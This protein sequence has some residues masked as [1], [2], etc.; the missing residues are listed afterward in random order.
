LGNQKLD[1]DR[2]KEQVN[3]QR[4][5]SIRYALLKNTEDLSEEESDMVTDISKDNSVTSL[6]YQMNMTP[7]QSLEPG[8][9]ELA[10]MYLGMCID[11][12]DRDCSKNFKALSKT[13]RKY[14]DGIILAL[15]SGVNNGYKESLNG[16]IQFSKR[17]ANGCHKE[18]GLVRMVFFRDSL[19]GLPS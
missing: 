3:G 10:R 1:K 4:L 7:R 17:S 8:D 9:P 14:M 19:R 18:E 5:K 12:V 2:S 15:S 11:W 6:S 16:R 13:V